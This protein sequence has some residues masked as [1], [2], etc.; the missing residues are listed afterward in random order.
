MKEGGRRRQS[1]EPASVQL[2]GDDDDAATAGRLRVVQQ[3]DAEATGN[4]QLRGDNDVMAATQCPMRL[5]G[6]V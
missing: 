6:K 4:L 2:R 3:Y 5:F 1:A